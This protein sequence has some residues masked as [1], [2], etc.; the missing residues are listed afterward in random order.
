MSETPQRIFTE[1]ELRQYDGT[2][3]R[4]AYVAYEGVVYDVS[5]APLWRTGLHQA[6]HYAGLDL[7]RSLRKA[8]HDR[9]VFGRKYIRAVGILKLDSS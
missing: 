2:K 7:T 3:G 4:P 5:A 1:A 8:P 6:L 9:S